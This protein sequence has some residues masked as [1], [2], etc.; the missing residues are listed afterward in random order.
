MVL[1]VYDVRDLAAFKSDLNRLV[2]LVVGEA[3]SIDVRPASGD[4]TGSLVVRAPRDRHEI[5]VS[6]FNT[7]RRLKNNEPNL[8]GI[9]LEQIIE[10]PRE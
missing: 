4:T 1:A 2:R 5:L 6:I 3:G 7:A 9:T 10:K 8:P